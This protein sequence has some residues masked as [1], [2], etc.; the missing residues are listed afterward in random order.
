MSGGAEVA[1]IALALAREV[2]LGY[3]RLLEAANLTEEEKQLHYESLK[4]EFYTV[5]LDMIPDPE[6]L[7]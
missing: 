4:G 3:F 6:D 2:G 7:K 5:E 1:L